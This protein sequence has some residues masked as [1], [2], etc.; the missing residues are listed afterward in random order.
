LDDLAERIVGQI[1]ELGQRN[2]KPVG[3]RLVPVLILIVIAFIGAAEIGIRNFERS[4]K[5]Q[6][7]VKTRSE[8]PGKLEPGFRW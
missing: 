6:N 8:N 4:P 5:A 3:I 7:A 1:D 2:F